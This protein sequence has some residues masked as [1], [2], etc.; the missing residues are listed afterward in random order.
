MEK[1]KALLETVCRETGVTEQEIKGPQ[2][3]R[4]IADARKIFWVIATEQKICS[5][6]RAAK[7]VGKRHSTA[8][9][10]IKQA[11]GLALYDPDFKW[12]MQEI[13]LRVP[14]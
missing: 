1:L 3:L 10:M 8:A 5:M 2:K 11:K 6:N 12:L 9:V 7:Y 14:A 13:K 4:R